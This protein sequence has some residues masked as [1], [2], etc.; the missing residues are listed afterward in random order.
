MHKS[1]EI[2]IVEGKERK[3]KLNKTVRAQSQM[4]RKKFGIPPLMYGHLANHLGKVPQITQEEI[5][6]YKSSS[7]KGIISS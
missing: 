1:K 4:I 3:S 5:D 6:E 7:A 2:L